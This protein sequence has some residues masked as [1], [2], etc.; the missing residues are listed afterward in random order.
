MTFT[1]NAVQVL[2][3]IQM[4]ITEESN[5]SAVGKEAPGDVF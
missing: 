3:G 2:Y 1:L 4:H 5:A